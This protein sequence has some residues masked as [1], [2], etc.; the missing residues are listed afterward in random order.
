MN[1]RKTKDSRPVNESAPGLSGLPERL[2]RMRER[3]KMSQ[4]RLSECCGLGK[5][6]VA[7]YEAGQKLPSAASLVQLAD[8][9]DVSTDFL[10]GRKNY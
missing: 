5:N 7:T 9:F 4:T 6:T 1:D 10:L 3:E 8:F 2:R